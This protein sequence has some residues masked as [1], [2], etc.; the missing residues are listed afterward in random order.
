M[1]T[2]A[3]NFVAT[4]ANANIPITGNKSSQSK[5]LKESGIILPSGA[6]P[7]D[8][9]ERFAMLAWTRHAIA[10]SI[11]TSKWPSLL[12]A[13]LLTSLR[14][15]Y[16]IPAAKADDPHGE[17]DLDRLSRVVAIYMPAAVTTDSPSAPTPTDGSSGINTSRD[18]KR[19]T[20]PEPGRRRRLGECF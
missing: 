6:S 9:K 5:H 11:A 14:T 19:P 16:P 10:N 15:L 13:P 12:S 3:M 8:V 20:A 2:P 7:A 4:C 17:T 18:K 1:T